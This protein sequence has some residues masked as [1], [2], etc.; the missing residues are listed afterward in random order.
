M[1]G[2]LEQL[3]TVCEPHEI[4]ALNEQEFNT[5]CMAMLMMT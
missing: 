3:K 4:M 5:F 2:L 1:A